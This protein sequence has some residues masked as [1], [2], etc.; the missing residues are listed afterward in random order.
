MMTRL[1]PLRYFLYVLVTVN[2]VMAAIF[3]G[4]S[5]VASGPGL[6]VILPAVI[7]VSTVSAWAVAREF[8]R[9]GQG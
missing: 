3:L 5:L 6:L 2:A 9:P 1:P 8:S 7:V 4:W